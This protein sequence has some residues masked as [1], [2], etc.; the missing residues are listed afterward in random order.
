LFFQNQWIN[1]VFQLAFIHAL[2][3]H[4][5]TTMYFC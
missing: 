5:G 4:F 3:K 2:C 1:H